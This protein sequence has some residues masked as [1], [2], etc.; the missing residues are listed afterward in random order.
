MTR[1][2]TMHHGPDQR[3]VRDGAAADCHQEATAVLHPSETHLHIYAPLSPPAGPHSGDPR[4][5]GDDLRQMEREDA[6]V[7]L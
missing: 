1:R 7:S 2:Y 5:C 3:W 4:A 6:V